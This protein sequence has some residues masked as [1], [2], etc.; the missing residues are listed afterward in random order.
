M[1]GL[2][3]ILQSASND[4]AASQGI[5]RFGLSLLQSKGNFGNAVG[6]AGLQGLQGAQD[7]RNQQFQ[8][9]I[10]QSQVDQMKRQQQ[11]Q[12]LP[13]QYMKPPSAPAVDATGGMETA[14]TNPNNANGPGGFDFAGY[15]N[16]LM[17]ID[18]MQAL[19][20][21]ALTKK[22]NTPIK[23]GSGEKLLAPGTFSTLASNPKEGDTPKITQLM[24]QRDQL[25]PNDPRRAIYSDAIDRETRS[26]SPSLIQEYEYAK[27]QNPNVG[28]F[29]EWSKAQKRAGAANTNVKVENQLG[30]GLAK[31]V[32]PM[33][34]ESYDSAKGAQQSITNADNLIKAVDSGKVLAGPGATLRLKLAQVQQGVGLGNKETADQITS[35]RAAIQGLAQATVAARGQ[36]KGQGQ[37]RKSVV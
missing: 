22:D 21:Q 25:P 34:K 20:F 18:P 32:G 17:G 1:A 10:R 7:Y 11:L 8:N 31:E 19:Q 23:L 35:T 24:A 16:A 2:L 26:S 15:T 13:A 30:T 5:L 29:D 4:P 6:Q 33:V 3:D 36:L 9:Q 12:G 37:D 14:T 27:Q 28:S